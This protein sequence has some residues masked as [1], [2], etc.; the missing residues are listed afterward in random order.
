MDYIDISFNQV[1]ATVCFYANETYFRNWDFGGLLVC[2]SGDINEMNYL[3][4]VPKLESNNANFLGLLVQ[5]TN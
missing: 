2:N 4:L 1:R 5:T 3:Q